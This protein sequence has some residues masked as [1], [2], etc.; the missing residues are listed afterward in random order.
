VASAPASAFSRDD[1]HKTRAA[2]HSPRRSRRKASGGTLMTHQVLAVFKNQ[3]SAALA[4]DRLLAA[5]IAE[6]QISVLADDAT[7]PR[8]G[9]A[10]KSA[11]P[12]GVA[13]GATIGGALG[14]IAAGAA[15]VG[16]VAI[17]GIGILAGPL[18]AAIA[19]AGAGGAAGGAIGGLIGLGIPK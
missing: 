11:G 16:T 6:P 9:I 15:A 2:S 13:T 8:I 1:N 3:Q 14:A 10:A 18:V 12:E 19:G 17:P 5:G 4:A 7:S